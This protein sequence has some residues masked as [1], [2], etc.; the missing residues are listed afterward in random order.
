[1]QKSILRRGVRWAG[2]NFREQGGREEVGRKAGVDKEIIVSG[3]PQSCLTHLRIPSPI[4]PGP[5]VTHTTG[6]PFL[7]RGL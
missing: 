5:S 6:W 2:Q 1:M 7:M 3:R 4:L